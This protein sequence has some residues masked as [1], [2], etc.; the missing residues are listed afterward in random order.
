MRWLPPQVSRIKVPRRSEVPRVSVASTASV[1]C[2]V[3][4]MQLHGTAAAK[5]TRSL[6][7]TASVGTWNLH[8]AQAKSLGR[9]F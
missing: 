4:W 1:S 2:G 3:E 6:C 8:L 5:L 9:G 7:R